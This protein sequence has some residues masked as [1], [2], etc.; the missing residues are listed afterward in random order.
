MASNVAIIKYCALCG[1]GINLIKGDTI[2]QCPRCRKEVCASCYDPPD[3]LCAECVAPVLAKS[4]KARDAAL[5]ARLEQQKAHEEQKQLEERQIYDS[6]ETLLATQRCFD[7]GKALGFFDKSGGHKRCKTCRNDQHDMSGQGEGYQITS[8]Y[9]A[10]AHEGSNWQPRV[11]AKV[12]FLKANNLCCMCGKTLKFLHPRNEFIPVSH[13]SYGDFTCPWC[14]TSLPY[15][16]GLP[17]KRE[18]EYL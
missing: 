10:H 8:L 1:R 11:K 3:R 7:C 14:H 12:R 17:V 2:Y 4:A 18:G 9:H 6:F 5:N 15:L 16:C 13:P